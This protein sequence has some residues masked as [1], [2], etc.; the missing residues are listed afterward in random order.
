MSY[1]AT[2]SAMSP[3]SQLR[4]GVM[5]FCLLAM[6]AQRDQYGFSLA[7]RV[8]ALFATHEAEGTVYPLLARLRRGGLVTTSWSESS[9]GPPRRYYHLS[10]DGQA[11]LDAY[12]S[13]WARLNQTIQL[14]L[15]GAGGPDA[16]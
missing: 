11:A 6:I 5:E 9:A 1:M 16:Q 12:K 4:R 10:A 14:V 7:R 13:E 15:D 8:S 3:S 2:A